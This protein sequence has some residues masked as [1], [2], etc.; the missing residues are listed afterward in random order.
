MI[1]TALTRYSKLD[2]SKETADL[3]RIRKLK[4][5]GYHR[6]RISKKGS[7]SKNKKRI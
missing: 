1:S 5:Q 3:K 6:K 4:K 7:E 2:K